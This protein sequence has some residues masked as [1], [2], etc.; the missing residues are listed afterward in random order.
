MKKAFHQSLSISQCPAGDKNML[1]SP[2]SVDFSRERPVSRQTSSLAT[3][4]S[5]QRHGRVPGAYFSSHVS[6]TSGVRCP[7]MRP[8][9]ERL[10]WKGFRCAM[11]SAGSSV[12]FTFALSLARFSCQFAAIC[13]QE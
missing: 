2:F 9:L 10:G 4:P 3:L 12:S 8:W 1:M 11:D 6:R 7:T 13:R 5:Q